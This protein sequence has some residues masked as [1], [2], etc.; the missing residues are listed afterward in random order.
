MNNTDSSLGRA[1]ARNPRILGAA[2][3]A[4]AFAIV[5][6]QLIMP[7]QDAEHGAR[8]ITASMKFGAVA[9]MLLLISISLILFGGKAVRFF[10]PEPG[11]SKVLCYLVA[12]VFGIL[13]FGAAI[14][15]RSALE[16][17]GYTFSF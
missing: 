15:V 10:R 14:A 1:I 2:M 5:Y 4:V 3:S 9:L 6:W 11:E 16:A 7:L 17:R 12:I 13:S 8:E